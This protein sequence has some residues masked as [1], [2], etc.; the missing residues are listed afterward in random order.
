MNKYFYYKLRDDFE[1]SP[2]EFNIM[3]SDYEELI[4]KCDKATVQFCTGI[5]VYF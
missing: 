1:L 5:T 3:L 4:D 2:N